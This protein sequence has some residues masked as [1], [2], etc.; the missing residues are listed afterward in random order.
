MVKLCFAVFLLGVLVWGGSC[1]AVLQ[2]SRKLPDGKIALSDTLTADACAKIEYTSQEKHPSYFGHLKITTFSNCSDHDQAYHTGYLE[3]YNTA[4]LMD[5]Q[6]K[7]TIQKV[8][9][10]GIVDPVIQKFFYD[11]IDWTN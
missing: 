10:S 1:Q 2:F 6:Y 5:A 7:N 3:G 11:Q 4:P 9:S 8:N